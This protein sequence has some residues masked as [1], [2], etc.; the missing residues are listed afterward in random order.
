MDVYNVSACCPVINGFLLLIY[1]TEPTLI[2]TC[3]ASGRQELR[4]N[5][6]LCFSFSQE[7]D[8]KYGRVTS[9]F[10][11]PKSLQHHVLLTSV[12]WN[13][14]LVLFWLTDRDV[15]TIETR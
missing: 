13:Q 12:K 7:C 8:G 1:I 5:A 11:V 6:L 4:Y 14:Y 2:N 15:I 3:H 9:G 10:D